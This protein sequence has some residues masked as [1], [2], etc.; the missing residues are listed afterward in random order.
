[1]I[2]QCLIYSPTVI[3]ELKCLI[4]SLQSKNCE[5]PFWHIAQCWRDEISLLCSRLKT[6]GVRF[7]GAV[8]SHVGEQEVQ[9]LKDHVAVED[10]NFFIFIIY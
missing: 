7:G 2:A 6:S 8:I 10:W 9:G 3:R 1:L 4:Y 5:E